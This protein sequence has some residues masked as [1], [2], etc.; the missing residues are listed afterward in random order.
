VEHRSIDVGTTRLHVVQE[1]TGQ[2]V[3]LLHGFP[4]FW[5]SWR[6]Q[7]EALAQRG[8]SV[9]APDLRGY[10]LSDKPSGIGRYKM[11]YLVDDVIGL[12]SVL[13][14]SQAHV[15]GHDW[16]GVIAWVLAARHPERVERLAIL[17]APHPVRMAHELMHPRQLAR[18]SY[19]FLFQVPTLPE[20]ML[21]RRGFIAQTFRGWGLR[22]GAINDADLQRY[23]EAIR[24]PGAARSSLNYYRAAFRHPILRLP[25]VRQPTLVLWGERDAA[26]G[27]H[28]LDG[29]ESHASDLRVHRLPQASHWV[30][31][32]CPDEVNA[33]LID[34]FSAARAQ[35]Q[36]QREQHA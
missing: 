34:F 14:M 5:Y 18:S 2:P 10:N 15:V 25:R 8:F 23:E 28:L 24:I 36:P 26:L 4:E 22:D 32:E 17:N 6:H 30:Q 16:G 11:D 3:V 27:P 21:R 19:M 7:I 31:Q 20:V 1:G 35:P 29:L 9:V 33:A 12:M 13:G